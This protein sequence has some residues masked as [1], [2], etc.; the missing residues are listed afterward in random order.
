MNSKLKIKKEY[1]EKLE[2]IRK[3]K[4]IKVKN[5]AEKYIK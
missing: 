4:F 5:F 1:Q 3:E 2:V